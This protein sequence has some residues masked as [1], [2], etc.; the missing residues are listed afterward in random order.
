M[1]RHPTISPDGRDESR[2]YNAMMVTDD[3]RRPE[4]L[5]LRLRDYNYAQ[6][7][8]YFVTICTQDRACLFGNIVE[9][10]MVFNEAGLIVDTCWHAIPKHF[11][12]MDVDEFVIMPNHL[13]GILLIKP[14]PEGARFIA[15]GSNPPAMATP[16]LVAE[17]GAMNR[18]PTLGAVVRAFKARV[19][20]ALGHPIW[21]RNYYDHIVRSETALHRIREYIA[22]N[23]AQW[24]MDREN[25]DNASVYQ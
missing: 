7:G 21:Q 14:A 4:R 15:P 25:P 11:P 20:H 18:A 23:P 13:H 24:A 6:V 9:A 12:H 17:T 1:N 5:S 3:T 16:A 19:T 2:P 8:A 22:H 10:A